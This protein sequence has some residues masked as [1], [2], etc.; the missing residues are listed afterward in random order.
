MKKLALLVLSLFVTAQLYS[1]SQG[2][3]YQAVLIDKNDQEIPGV[4]I[5]G[6]IIP[7][8]PI[9]VRFSILDLAGT[10]DYQEEHSTST[11]EFGMINLTIGIG[12]QT[13]ASP[14]AFS[15][16]DWNGTPKNLKVEISLGSTDVLYTDFSDQVLTFVPYAYHKNITA[17]GTMI[18]EDVTDLNSDLN[19]NNGSP[20][21]LTGTIDVDGIANLNSALN[22]N[23]SSAT[24]L[25]GELNVQGETTLQNVNL[26]TINSI[27]NE[28]TF[29]ATFENTNDGVG[30][31]IKIK[32]GKNRAE[33]GNPMS[34]GS[35]ISQDQIDR[36]KDLIGCEL[37]IKAK[38]PIIKDLVI[39]GLVA[40]VNM[41]ANL[42]LGIGN[43]LIKFLNASLNIPRI[44]AFPGFDWNLPDWTGF[45]S[46]GFGID[47]VY[48]GPI[49]L[50]DVPELSLSF[51]EGL[52]VNIDGVQIQIRDLEI[53]SP[54][55][56][57]IPSICLSDIIP[58]PLNYE[59]EFIQ[60]S[61]I[62]DSRMGSIRAQSVVDWSQNYLNPGFLWGLKGA[63]TSAIDKNHA[64]YHF[65]GKITE[66]LTNY[67]KIGVEYTSG[68]GDY[69]EWLERLD[70]TEAISP[71]DIVG[72]I[73]GKI[74]KNLTCAEQIMAVSSNPIVLG[75]TPV[76]GKEYLGN[77]IA[78]MGQI[79]V[80]IMGPVNTGDY[81]V[82]KGD[83]LGY[84]VAM[85]PEDM[86]MEDFKYTVGRSWEVNITTGP[87]MVNTVV[88]MHNGDYLNILKGYE[89]R[90]NN[91]ENR[92]KRLEEK[93]DLLLEI[94]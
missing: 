8:R 57:G 11:D 3:S 26:T 20:T 69:A 76:A 85:S 91:Q 90:F 51:L 49:D 88:G 31:G 73:G 92:L 70:S 28:A 83:I 63:Y 27:S 5:S 46:V 6:N 4:D 36:M 34:P 79:P 15:G 86:S 38:L 23:N 65:K 44:Q 93:L 35:G 94:K 82:G 47:P 1:Q 59:N 89:E 67:T 60:F 17:T 40:D 55:F 72:V 54:D 64:K 58:N 19:V 75:N 78:F 50:P 2:I 30:D 9:L 13:A 81:I 61:D 12:T 74:T 18:I 41:Q 80:K 87:K 24:N 71:G 32:L 77:V 37:D 39:E 7:N 68:N 52:S 22:V 43:L 48:I 10:I 53:E 16:I 84:G 33:T 42:A 29:V 21:Y 14:I 56:W 25:S 45:G 66:A 62:N